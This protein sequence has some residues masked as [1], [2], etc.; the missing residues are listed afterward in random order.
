MPNGTS[1]PAARDLRTWFFEESPPGR[2]PVGLVRRGSRRS[3]HA[4]PHVRGG[5]HSRGARPFS[6]RSISN[7]GDRRPSSRRWRT[8]SASRCRRC[9]RRSKW[10][11]LPRRLRPRAE[12]RR[13]FTTDRSDEP[14][15]RRPHG[16][17]AVGVRQSDNPQ[18][19]DRSPNRRSEMPHWTSR[20]PSRRASRSSWSPSRPEPLW[21]DADPQRLQQVLSNL[22]DNAMKYTGPG[23]RI[24]LAADR[25][26]ARGDRERRRHRTRHRPPV[27]G[28]YLRFIL[29]VRPAEGA[30][31]G[32]GLSVV[33]EIVALHQGR[34]EARSGGLGTAASSSSHCNRSGR[35]PRLPCDRRAGVR[36]CAG[37]AHEAKDPRPSAR[38]FNAKK[39]LDSAGVKRRIV[40]FPRR[41]AG[42][43]PRAI[44]RLMSS[45]F[46]TA[47][48][49]F[50]CSPR[51]AA[52]PSSR[53]LG[54]RDFF[55]EG[56]LAGQPVRMGTA[57]AI[58]ASTI[59]IIEKAGD[60]A[61]AARASLNSRIDFC[62]TSSAG[63]SGSRRIWS[64]SCSTPAKSASPGR[65]CSWPVTGKM[66]LTSA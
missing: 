16:R 27:V 30:G 36:P 28:A 38:R 4:R 17:D 15:D 61:A 43:F 58:A 25:R 13:R 6:R 54:A 41:A 8:S 34:I 35:R 64:T 59:L 26:A 44:R 14:R 33:R 21:V 23:G 19:A 51:P 53:M 47:P 12:P 55:G 50:R 2:E 52:R 42:F 40:K 7:A 66:T 11:V 48:S 65:C 49:G 56:C 5:D 62:P 1:P 9:S 39:F 3:S 32:I 57:T 29:Q 63:T 20:R 45:I 46:R 24:S 18:A 37:G 60:G 22:L 31:L 10:S